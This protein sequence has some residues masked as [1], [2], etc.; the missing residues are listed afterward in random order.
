[1]LRDDLQQDFLALAADHYRWM[2]FLQRLRIADRVGHIVVTSVQSCFFLLEHPLDDLQRFVERLQ[3]S[4]NRL[5][6]DSET[7][8]LELEP[9]RAE[10]EVE[11][12]VADLIERRRHLRRDAR[13]CD[14]CCR[15]PSRRFARV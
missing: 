9:S 14:R 10:T 6:V 2:R 15:S 1:M 13:D 7:L 5:E 11:T 3:P 4:G 8:M 12:A